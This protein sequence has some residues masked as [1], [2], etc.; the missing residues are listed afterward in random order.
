MRRPAFAAALAVV[1]GALVS[2]EAFALTVVVEPVAPV[3]VGQA[4]TFR[5]A[6]IDEAEGEVMLTWIFGD[7]STSG[8]A[9]DRQVTPRLSIR[10]A[11]HRDRAG[12]RRRRADQHVVRSNRASSA[13]LAGRPPIHPASSSTRAIAGCWNVNPDN[14]SVSVV[15][16]QT[17]SL[18]REI[19]V[20]DEPHSLAQAPDG[21]IWVANQRSDEIVV[22]DRSSG[23]VQARIPLPYASQPRALAIAPAG[24]AYVSLFASGRLVE[25][26]TQ[27]RAITPRGRRRAD[28][29]RRLGRR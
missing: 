9:A 12:R 17:L 3:L 7:G 4:Q 8:P 20:G 18:V 21:T 13:H 16:G 6:R 14:D 28:A 19:S 24:K 27:T 1:V 2:S 11:L 5:V 29:G 22:L 26:D 23:D 25:I 15:D 10:G